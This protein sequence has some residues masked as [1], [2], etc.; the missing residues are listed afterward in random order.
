MSAAPQPRRAGG[1]RGIT[2][3]EI[4]VV[5]ALAGLMMSLAYRALQSARDSDL[6]EE[7]NRVMAIMRMAYNG[8]NGTGQHIRVVFDLEEQKFWMESCAGEIRLKQ[9]DDDKEEE[10]DEDKLKEMNEKLERAEAQLRESG[11]TSDQLGQVLQ[12]TS[13]EK[14]VEAAAAIEGIRIGSAT[15]QPTG[16][17]LLDVRNKREEI[18]VGVVR[19]DLGVRIQKVYV[20]HLLEPVTEGRVTVN[21][22]PLGFAEASGNRG[23][24]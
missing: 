11:Q 1:E 2:L 15:C 8:A 5:L 21:F 22:F 3:L 14:A 24:A 23:C 13:P 6:R 7:A 12:A 16:N 9:L 10:V 18:P 20:K 17:P 4:M 19:Q